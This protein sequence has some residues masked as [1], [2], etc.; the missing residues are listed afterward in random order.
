[1]GEAKRK[2]EMAVP[3]VYHHTSTLRT[4]LI[5]MSGVIDLE[6]RSVGAVHPAFGE[7]FTDPLARRP[8]KDFPAL[9]WFTTNIDIPKCLI[10]MAMLTKDKATGEE[11]R[12]DLTPEMA[13]AYALQRMA[14]GFRIA[15]IPVVPWIEH[16]GY[17][18]EEGADLNETARD[19]GDNP[20]D[21][22]VSE[23]PVDVALAS[24]I[25]G[26]GSVMK[27][28]LKRSDAYLP[29]MKN[30]VALCRAIPGTIIPPSWIGSPE[31]EALA[32]QS[33][34]AMSARPS[35]LPRR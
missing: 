5:W 31:A 34:F 11:K 3:T 6:G 19:A 10:A 35:L 23:Q 21:W 17:F 32:R 4:N 16:P 12:I 26:S 33:N 8:M 29:Q 25:W 15:D 2:R 28:K 18:T 7:V 14:I 30:M 22:Y 1:M 27:P 24:E 20:G 9:A 13:N